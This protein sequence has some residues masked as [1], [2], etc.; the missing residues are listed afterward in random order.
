MDSGWKVEESFPSARPRRWSSST[1]DSTLFVEAAFGQRPDSRVPCRGVHCQI[2]EITVILGLRG[3]PISRRS[4][5]K[6][7]NSAGPLGETTFG[8]PESNCRGHTGRCVAWSGEL[9]IRSLVAGAVLVLACAS[10]RGQEVDR[11]GLGAQ[12]MSSF[13]AIQRLSTD[14]VDRGR[15][16]SSRSQNW[17]HTGIV[18]CGGRRPIA[19]CPR[20]YE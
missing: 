5:C 19:S 12:L 3:A 14:G 9:V 18:G 10:A 2:C 6:R 8:L 11:D 15:P 17:T 20:V 7:W 1:L 4:D 16:A 13:S